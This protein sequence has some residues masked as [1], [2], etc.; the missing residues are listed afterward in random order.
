M[1]TIFLRLLNFLIFAI[2]S[3][4]GVSSVD[5]VMTK[6]GVPMGEFQVSGR[7]KNL[8][9]KPI[10]NIEVEVQ[11]IQS[12]SLGIVKTAKDGSFQVDYRGWPHR[13]VY[14]ISRDVDGYRNGA[15]QSD[16]SLVKLDYPIEDWN[17][18]KAIVEHDIVLK[19]K[20]E[21]KNRRYK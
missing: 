4:F 21:R 14:V 7:V 3:C 6:Y 20:S 18:G 17:R 15:Y 13:E 1:K 9:S 12:R 5:Q 8:K 10:Q 16:T 19:Y 11:D 2:L